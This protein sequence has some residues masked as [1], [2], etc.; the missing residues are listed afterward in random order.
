[1]SR[2]PYAHRTL[3]RQVQGLYKSAKAEPIDDPDGLGVHRSYRFSKATTRYLERHID[4]LSN[5]PRIA[6]VE[7][8][9]KGV[10]VVYSPRTNADLRHSFGLIEAGDSAE[11]SEG[12]ED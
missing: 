8:T 4:A 3:V 7:S 1:M 6:S 5:D 2:S 11:D 9:E 10:V 12:A